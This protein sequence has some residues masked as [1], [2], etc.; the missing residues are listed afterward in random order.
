MA[1]YLPS[2]A[3]R[4]SI[5]E[6]PGSLPPK[7]KRARTQYSCTLC[8][9]GKL[10][11]NKQHPVCDQCIKRSRESSCVYLAPV[12]R[13]KAS[14]N[15]KGRIKNLERLVID[16]MNNGESAIA[17]APR[18]N[19]RRGGS[20]TSSTRAET[21]QLRRQSSPDLNQERDTEEELGRL[22]ISGSDITYTGSSHWA[23][24]LSEI[25]E[26]KTYLENEETP[27]LD[28]ST[29]ES[30]EPD[31]DEVDIMIYAAP[32]SRQ[33]L[34]DNL[35][36]KAICDGY[37]AQWFAFKDPGTHIFH[38]ATFQAEYA[39]F[40]QNHETFPIIFYAIIYGILCL[41]ETNQE[42]TGRT[43]AS[44]PPGTYIEP[45]RS[46]KLC[47]SAIALADYTKPK[48]YTIEALL[49]LT[50]CE[51]LTNNN[52]PFRVWT[53][54]GLI[55][56]VALRMGYHRDPKFFP[57]IT[58]FLGE[59]RRRVWCLIYHVD[60]LVS[61]Q[62]G[63]PATIHK[64]ESDTESSRNLLDQDFGPNC[65]ELPPERPQDDL[66]PSSYIRTKTLLCKVFAFAADQSQML[67]LPAYSDV[68]KLDRDLLNAWDNIPSGLRS[69]SL[70]DSITD[71]PEVIITRVHLSL[72]FHKTRAV[73]HRR[74][75]TKSET[76]PEYDYS[77]TCCLSSA[78][79]TLRLHEEIGT[80][81][82]PGKVL[83]THRWFVSSLTAHDFLLAAMIICL[84]LSLRAK[85]DTRA[86]DRSSDQDQI[87]DSA[88]RYTLNASY[89]IWR[90]AA[91]H[92]A[93]KDAEE[94]CKAMAIIL[95]KVDNGGNLSQHSIS[96]PSSISN[97]SSDFSS[98]DSH[99]FDIAPDSNAMPIVPDIFEPIPDLDWE[100]WDH[101][102]HGIKGIEDAE[103]FWPMDI[104]DPFN[105]AASTLF[106]QDLNSI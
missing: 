105:S 50:H 48:P 41:G 51:Y 9:Q 18:P 17:N 12:T 34:F 84:E 80:A 44:V 68:M 75:M 31:P 98:F 33:D 61:F 89:E 25:T 62:L 55:I 104:S 30:P 82:E 14:E 67:T 27:Q 106:T 60:V 56:R 101:H 16:L 74:Y 77:H 58:P 76:N 87:S 100:A 78:M 72:L 85:P 49:L 8:R 70:A 2:G 52:A 69:R 3:P 97:N 59:M 13:P 73:L 29:D 1:N 22:T 90:T 10:K 37:V 7:Q 43:V 36:D 39:R 103:T 19:A 24:I 83:F 46:R 86:A 42:K 93:T 21:D 11:C 20:D 81:I 23:A 64:I 6:A 40:W 57:N 102:I 66:T 5:S 54:I 79:A 35:P 32:M 71:R 94:A 26:V 53:M 88:M 28:T 92:L 99:S 38:A 96:A 45:G 65:T 15:V 91:G 95:G 4:T 63:L 47:A